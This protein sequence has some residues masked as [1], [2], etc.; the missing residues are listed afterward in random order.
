MYLFNF[1]A[2]LSICVPLDVFLF[3]VFFNNL[4]G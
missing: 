2:T 4:K 3:Q 1:F